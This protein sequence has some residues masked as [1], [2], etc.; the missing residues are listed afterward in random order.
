MYF[1]DF[2]RSVSQADQRLA[3]SLLLELSVQQGSLG[4]MLNSVLLLLQLEYRNQ[5]TPDNRYDQ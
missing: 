3:L 1:S 2:V 5:S 4:Q